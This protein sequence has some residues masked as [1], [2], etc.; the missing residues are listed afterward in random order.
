[1]KIAIGSDHRGFLK[2]QEVIEFFTNH[3]LI[4]VDKFYL[5]KS[6]SG[7]Y[8]YPDYAHEVAKMV[9][10]GEA[11]CGILICGTGI[12]MCMAANKVKGAR[13]ALVHTPLEAAMSKRHNNSN[14]LCFGEHVKNICDVV[15]QWIDAE[16]SEE[17]RHIRRVANIE[18]GLEEGLW[19]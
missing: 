13:A 9:S 1:M 4:D 6:L 19:I 12:G 8:D 2:K 15:I 14:I 3:T 7:D 11:D 5:G 10:K 18:P 16:F 17:E